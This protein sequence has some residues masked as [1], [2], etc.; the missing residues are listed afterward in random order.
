MRFHAVVVDANILIRD[1]PLRGNTLQKMVKT[2][3][4]Y[5]LEICIPEVV[6]DECIGNYAQSVE[7]AS[8]ELAILSD[9]FDRLDL[10][11][12]LNKSSA[13]KKLA[14]SHQKYVRRLN[15]FISGNDVVVLPYPAVEHKIVVERMYQKRKP[16]TDG[17]VREKGYKD[18]LII[19]S[20]E[21]YLRRGVQD[22]VL[23]LTENVADFACAKAVARKDNGLLPL[24]DDYGLPNVYVA[25]SP[26]LLFSALSS[27]LGQA[28]SAEVT[29][30][31]NEKL[32]SHLM[33][34]LSLLNAESLIEMFSSFLDVN[35]EQKTICLEVIQSQIKTDDEAGI[36]EAK[37]IIRIS[38][39]CHFS[40]DNFDVQAKIVDDQFCFMSKVKDRAFQKRL[41]WRGEWLEEFSN[42]EYDKEFLFEY[43]DINYAGA[44]NEVD[45]LFFSISRL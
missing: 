3:S 4:F 26:T 42:V 40:V 17:G 41:P 33:E 38:F 32:S 7:V 23:L 37:G 9:K 13:V 21:E 44:I 6:R 31:F 10:Q 35:I 16:F 25:R 27:N 19:A 12:A 1:Y 24:D 2:K 30:A 15:E 39:K 36:M 28:C 43:V 14:S 34:R 45:E 8:K 29:K 11:G 20:I 18:Y 22:N 5:A